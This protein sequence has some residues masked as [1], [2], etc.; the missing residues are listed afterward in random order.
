MDNAGPDG[1]SFTGQGAISQKNERRL[2]QTLRLALEHAEKLSIWS[3]VP[4]F[5]LLGW[6]DFGSKVHGVSITACT[7]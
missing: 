3:K 5:R 4:R 2:Q 6:S 1:D 7:R